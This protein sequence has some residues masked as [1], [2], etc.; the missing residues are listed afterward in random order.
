MGINLSRG[1]T[2]WTEPRYCQDF[3]FT[4]A[5]L[6]T[7]RAGV[8]GGAFGGLIDPAGIKTGYPPFKRTNQARAPG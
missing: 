7:Y 4:S 6:F 8:A 3:A 2:N 5:P 1:T